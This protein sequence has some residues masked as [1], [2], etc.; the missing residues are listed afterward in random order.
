MTRFR[1]LLLRQTWLSALLL[2]CLVLHG[3]VPE[4]HMPQYDA[5]GLPVLKLCS[6]SS[7]PSPTPDAP[8]DTRQIHDAPSTGSCPFAAAAFAPSD[9]HFM[10]LPTALFATP[11][12]ADV[13]QPPPQRPLPTSTLPRGP[14][15][16]LA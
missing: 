14:P 5:A 3:L 16:F 9:L 7:V 10:L 8:S 2:G 15:G 13:E 11:I 12:P 4:G 6:G 1:H